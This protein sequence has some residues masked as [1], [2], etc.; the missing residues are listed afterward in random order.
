MIVQIKT[1]HLMYK[2]RGAILLLYPI[3]SLRR[4]WTPIGFSTVL[5]T[6]CCRGIKGPYPSTSLD[7]KLYLFTN[8]MNLIQSM[9]KQ[10]R[11][12]MNW[13]FIC[14]QTCFVCVDL[15]VVP[16]NVSFTGHT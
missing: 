1:P 10:A 5:L 13:S 6:V 16:N 14:N 7:K 2:M 9:R 15:T 12:R 3:L 11:Y 4:Q 8:L